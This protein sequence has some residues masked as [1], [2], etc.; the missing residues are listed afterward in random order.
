[1]FDQQLDVKT[2]ELEVERDKMIFSKALEL[3]R[4]RARARI[5]L[6]ISVRRNL[7]C[8]RPSLEK[9]RS[10]KHPQSVSRRGERQNALEPSD[11][12][13]SRE[14]QIQ[15]TKRQRIANPALTQPERH[16]IH[17]NSYVACISRNSFATPLTL[18]SPSAQQKKITQDQGLTAADAEKLLSLLKVPSLTVHPGKDRTPPNQTMAN[19]KKRLD[20]PDKSLKRSEDQA[21]EEVALPSPIAKPDTLQGDHVDDTS[22]CL[23]TQVTSKDFGV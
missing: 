17:H 20:N 12:I 2:T 3:R 14:T 22:T 1:M 8:L 10:E 21:K 4:Q 11:S 23:L 7:H 9:W 15:E 18:S 6:A 16:V 13:Q 19:T 5:S